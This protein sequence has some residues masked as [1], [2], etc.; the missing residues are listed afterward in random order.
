[1]EDG[2]S[3]PRRRRR[4][5]SEHPLARINTR[6]WRTLRDQVVREEPVCQ[7]RLP[8]CTIISE[9]ADHIKTRKT[10]PHLTYVRQNLRGSCI[11]CNR[12]RG[13]GNPRRMADIHRRAAQPA[14]ALKFFG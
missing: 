1:M 5:A 12:R 3:A 6:K 14:R 7:L 8:G 2:V 13:D 9:T 4:R 11:P 10:H